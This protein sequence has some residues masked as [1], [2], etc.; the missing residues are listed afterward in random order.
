MLL[1]PMD[2]ARRLLRHPVLRQQG[3]FLAVGVLCTVIDFGVFNGLWKG[4]G[5]D[6]IVANT[7]SF[8]VSAGASF[9][10]NRLWTFE[11]GGKVDWVREAIPFLVV[12]FIGLLLQNAAIWAAG[13]WLST[14]VL[15][16]NAAKVAGVG[17]IWFLKFFVYRNY[18]FVDRA[19]AAVRQD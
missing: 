1:R 7:G 13:R 17:T 6:K 18:V 12:S 9:A 10:I 16:I 11:M 2:L 3:K 15:V 4:V 8:L 14:G 5:F 19:P